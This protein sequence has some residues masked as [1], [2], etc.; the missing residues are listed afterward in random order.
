MICPPC[1]VGDHSGCE[2]D[3]RLLA[4]MRNE[5]DPDTYCRCY[6]W[7]A[8]HLNGKQNGSITA[9]EINDHGHVLG[10]SPT[11][12]RFDRDRYARERDLA[13]EEEMRCRTP[14]Q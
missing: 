14:I 3:V 8:A 13:E 9:D 4:F 1:E 11:D 7:D 5:P 10:I 2:G 12:Q 6:K